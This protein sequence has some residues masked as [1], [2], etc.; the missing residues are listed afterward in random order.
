[1]DNEEGVSYNDVMKCESNFK[2]I[3]NIIEIIDGYHLKSVEIM[4]NNKNNIENLYN[5]YNKIYLKIK[6]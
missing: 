6:K 3:N 1:M 4:K 2:K 5:L